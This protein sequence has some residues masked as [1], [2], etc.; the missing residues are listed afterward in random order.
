MRGKEPNPFSITV[1][2]DGT[3]C[4]RSIWATR[5]ADRPRQNVRTLGLET[6]PSG[7]RHHDQPRNGVVRGGEGHALARVPPDRVGTIPVPG[8]KKAAPYRLATAP[9]GP[10]SP[11]PLRTRWAGSRRTGRSRGPASPRRQRS[12]R[13]TRQPDGTVW[14]TEAAGNRIGRLDP[15]GNLGEISVPTV[16]AGPAGIAVADDGTVWFSELKGNAIGRLDPPAR[17]RFASTHPHQE[18]PARRIAVAPT[19]TSGSR[20]RLGKVGILTPQCSPRPAS[21]SQLIEAAVLGFLSSA[22]AKRRRWRKRLPCR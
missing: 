18:R 22:N 4:S 3:V 2:R 15:S 19:V 17:A 21:G 5:W 12:V 8:G 7:D 14:F 13:H 16:G 6:G 11:T 10:C 9:D 20:S 1:A